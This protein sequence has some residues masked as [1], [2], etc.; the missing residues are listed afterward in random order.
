LKELILQ[1]ST[2]IRTQIL[3]EV[4]NSVKH[5][6][7]DF[8]AVIKY[9]TDIIQWLKPIIDLTGYNVYP[10]CGIT[11]GLNWWYDKEKRGVILK[12]G[13][14]QWIHPRETSNEKILYI[15][16]PSSMDG[17]FIDIPT[18]I[19]V[20]LDLAY[21]GS[22]TIK[23]ISIANNVEYVFFSLS[24]AFAMRNIRTGWLF[25]LQPD[26]RLEALIHSAKYYNYFAHSIAEHIINK[27]D[28]DYVHSQLQ[29]EQTRV[30]NSLDF[31][32]SDSVWIATTT[33]SEYSKF[34]RANNIARLCLSPVYNV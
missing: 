25:T 15:S 1:Q 2:A 34:I 28:I 7:P 6:T 20:A 3:P 12:S 23:Q 33:D 16:C 13:D 9:K 4:Y 10:T 8:N 11:E 24:K 27:F 32:E 30:C 26:P 19:P 17:N 22:T 14:Y 5:I 29:Q 21:I 31:T 18:D